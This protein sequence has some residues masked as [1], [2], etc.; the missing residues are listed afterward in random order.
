M[1]PP[2]AALAGRP[3]RRDAAEATLTGEPATCAAGSGPTGA[4][5]GRREESVATVY[6]ARW[7]EGRG[8]VDVIGTGRRRVAGSLVLGG[9]LA[10]APG[11]WG[12]AAQLPV[13]IARTLA[14]RGLAAT[15]SP[16]T[17]LALA[18][19]QVGWAGGTGILLG[20]VDGGR[21]WSTQWHGRGRVFAI[22]APSPRIAY[23]A[24]D[25]GLLVTTD[26]GAHWRPGREP[27]GQR[28][29]LSMPAGA[30]ALTVSFPTAN[31][32][33]A[34]AALS[35]ALGTNP[36]ATALSPSGSTLYVSNATG[37]V[38]AVDLRTDRVAR[39]LALPGGPQAVALSPDGRRLYAVAEGANRL[40]L[41]DARS[42][43]LEASAATGL[44]PCGV[45]PAPDGRIVY[46]TTT[47]NV[48]D[49]FDAVTG[50]RV[51]AFAVPTGCSLAVSPDG[52]LAYL[53][54]IG[55]AN[56]AGVSVVDLA[57][58]HVVRT[59]V[60][61]E[62]LLSL[63]LGPHGRTLYVG[64][65]RPGGGGQ[66]SVLSLPDGTV[67]VTWNIPDL[68]FSL[69]VDPALK[70]LVVDSDGALDLLDLRSGRLVTQVRSTTAGGIVPGVGFALSP[71]GTAAYVP[72]SDATVA[73]ALRTGRSRVVS[74]SGVSTF[75]GFGTPVP[76]AG[77][78]LYATEDGG[79]TW[80]AVRTP[81]PVQSA[82]FLS[83]RVGFVADL[84]RVYRTGDGGRTWGLA[85]SAPLQ[86]GS[87][88]VGEAYTALA[89]GAHTAVVQIGLAEAA[90][91]HAPYIA[92][93]SLD[94]GQR[95]RPAVEE[96]YTHP[97]APGVNAPDGPGSYPG[98]FAVA[99]T[100]AVVYTGSTPAA[101]TAG[102]AVA[103]PHGLKAHTISGAGGVSALAFATARLG[104]VATAGSG[105][106]RLLRTT[107]G[108]ARWQQVY[109]TAAAPVFAISFL[110]ANVGFGLGTGGDGSAVLRTVDG[111]H[112]WRLVG[113]VPGPPEEQGGPEL[114]FATPSVGL[115]VNGA[116]ILYRTTDGGRTW[117]REPLGRAPLSAVALDGR[118]GCAVG[119]HAAY[120][121]HDGGATWRPATP[122]LGSGGALPTPALACAAVLAN[123]AWRGA[124][125]RF[126]PTASLV[127]V[128]GGHTAWFW[129]PEAAALYR[130]A[131]GGV[132]WEAV[133]GEPLGNLG[134]AS[135]AFPAP[136]VGYLLTGT[137]SLYRTD[138]GGI[139]WRLLP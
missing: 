13:P 8:T 92:F 49:A 124:I 69:A 76:E 10:L 105:G 103:G 31:V 18:S 3:R 35:P 62:S 16:F 110:A 2:D 70:R 24:T 136:T 33:Y 87:A 109:P 91:G 139:S 1:R 115:A 37:S 96:G 123:P 22:A 68:P 20:T 53:G 104:L 45:A 21:H 7:G 26:G 108:G 118:M 39:M 23:A 12:Q 82:C 66:V 128:V 99:R 120:T 56:G 84:A 114:A 72:A 97:G 58:G 14:E 135:F 100:G 85:L 78:H 122:D 101:G 28:S 29:C 132:R 86:S 57:A 67:K 126:E 54:G 38:T 81:V 74:T 93:V 60:A 32:G 127:G 137:G 9:V 51:A 47:T 130:T 83:P 131:D 111:G 40:A 75:D 41:V 107:D 30:C 17:A 77:G 133:L 88:T 48:L 80:R 61:G 113:R 34:V 36:V 117:R 73:V 44:N 6:R 46:V 19:P 27:D 79:R 94:R 4:W 138:D 119:G 112:S 15:P 90:M 50:R 43:R 102:V 65:A 25:R 89:C 98:P 42:L 63:A 95:W 55:A 52:R 129:S 116:G 106:G 125:S 11:I 5:G 64:A 121:T 134:S 71:D 59:L